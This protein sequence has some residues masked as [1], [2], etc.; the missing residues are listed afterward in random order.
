MNTEGMDPLAAKL[1]EAWTERDTLKEELRMSR[2][3]IARLK[4]SLR[5]TVASN[6]ELT[7]DVMFKYTPFGRR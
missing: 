4:E 5:L 7:H 2:Q 1:F 6:L 3:E